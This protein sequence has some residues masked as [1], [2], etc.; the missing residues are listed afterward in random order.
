M[1]ISLNLASPPGPRDRYALAWAIPLATVA[2]AVAVVLSVL[3]V[4]SVR[5]YRKFR[6][7]HAEQQQLESQL[8]SREVALRAGLDRPELQETYRRS[9]FVNSLIAKKTLSLPVLVAEVSKLMPGRV[10]LTGLS[11]S[12]SG[13]ELW[14]RFSVLGESEEGVE[15]F[16][17][18]LEDSAEFADVAIVSQGFDQEEGGAGSVTVVCAAKYLGAKSP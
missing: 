17:G 9:R 1:R 3:G 4:R 12:E 2:L 7:A 10:R 16:L 11:I 15:S 6:R 13:E 8:R 14:V 18:K 5:E